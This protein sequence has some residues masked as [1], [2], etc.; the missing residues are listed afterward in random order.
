MAI[1]RRILRNASMTPM[2]ARGA[3]EAMNTGLESVKKT[4]QVADL[5]EGAIQTGGRRSGQRY[6]PNPGRPGPAAPC[7]AP[8]PLRPKQR[9]DAIYPLRFNQTRIRH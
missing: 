5:G 3:V 8:K 6:S 9:P 7:P 1:I 4:H 2:G